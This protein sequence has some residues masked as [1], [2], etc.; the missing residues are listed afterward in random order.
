[1][2]F[3]L[4]IG[5]KAD[6]STLPALKDIYKIKNTLAKKIYDDKIVDVKFEDIILD[7]ILI[8]NSGD[9]IPTDGTIIWGDCSIDESMI[10][11]E[12]LPVALTLTQRLCAKLKSPITRTCAL[13][14]T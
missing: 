11:G 7:D 1:M 4:E 14:S 9:I 3:S 5:P 6:L 12:S 8:V 2:K 13:G 10:T